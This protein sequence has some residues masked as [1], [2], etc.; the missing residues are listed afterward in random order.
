MNTEHKSLFRSLFS[1]F[2]SLSLVFSLFIAV[3]LPA[4]AASDYW[5]DDEI[6]VEE[7][8][9]YTSK[10]EVALYLHTYGKL[11]GNFITKKEAKALGWQ[12]SKGN[13]DKVAP[14]KSIGGDHFG[15]Y[16][17]LLPEKKGRSYKECDINFNG[18]YRGAE[19]IIYS[20]DGLIFYTND[21]YQTFEQL[22]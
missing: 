9:S 15:N 13:L 14:G 11:P 2:L 18:S 12:S 3:A 19:R 22:Y 6:E 7:D 4:V 20:D 1:L 5:D 16:D 10:E 17:K 8:G 21:H